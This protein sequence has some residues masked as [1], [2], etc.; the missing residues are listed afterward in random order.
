V[1]LKGLSSVAV[2]AGLAIVLVASAQAD[3]RSYGNT[4]SITFRSVPSGDSFSG[5]V[6]SAKPRCRLRR[7]VVLRKRSGAD[8]RI[9]AARTR[10]GGA[11]EAIPPGGRVGAG[12]YYARMRRKVL[13]SGG[14]GFRECAAVTTTTVTVKR[15]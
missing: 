10:R 15:H 2:I 5:R 1:R 7:V 3:T 6:R 4:L 14:G 13:Q 8:Q 11:W 12:R 9:R